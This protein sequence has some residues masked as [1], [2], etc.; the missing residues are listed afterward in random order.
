MTHAE[1]VALK[2]LTAWN[3]GDTDAIPSAYTHDALTFQQDLRRIL[4]LAEQA[5]R[6]REAARGAAASLVAA[7]SLL[8]RG[9]KAAKR[10]SPSDRM[11]DQMLNDYRESL[12]TLRAALAQAQGGGE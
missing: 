8:E 11:F 7:I 9:G 4:T 12:E 6:L 1:I 3:I 2:R 5:L 10:V